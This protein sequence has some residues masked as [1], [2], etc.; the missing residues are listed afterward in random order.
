[1]KKVLTILM[2]SGLSLSADCFGIG[3]ASLS[4][5]NSARAIAKHS[6]LAKDVGLAAVGGAIV[7]GYQGC[8]S[9]CIS[10][11][12]LGLVQNVQKSSVVGSFFRDMSVLSAAEATKVTADGLLTSVFGKVTSIANAVSSVLNC[13]VTCTKIIGYLYSAYIVFNMLSRWMN[14][15]NSQRSSVQ[16]NDLDHVSIWRD[17]QPSL[18]SF[19]PAVASESSSLATRA[20]KSVVPSRSTSSNFSETIIKKVDADKFRTKISS[21]LENFKLESAYGSKVLKD[22]EEWRSEIL[23]ALEKVKGNVHYNELESLKSNLSGYCDS[24][25]S[26]LNSRVV[27]LERNGGDKSLIDALEKDIGT[28]VELDSE[29]W[30]RFYL[31]KKNPEASFGSSG[32]NEGNSNVHSFGVSKKK[33]KSRDID[34][35]KGKFADLL[36]VQIKSSLGE[37]AWGRLSEDR[38]RLLQDLN[39][40]DKNFDFGLLDSLQSSSLG[41]FDE[42]ASGLSTGIFKET[43][44]RQLVFSNDLNTV[45]DQQDKMRKIFID[46]KYRSDEEKPVIKMNGKVVNLY[47]EKLKEAGQDLQK[48]CEE[49]TK[50]LSAASASLAK[51]TP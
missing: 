40:L 16:E 49:Q 21:A 34:N 23:N 39:K 44:Q 26:S 13:A 3:G 28:I 15:V 24:M 10:P 30:D 50:A 27:K 45:R 51:D 8:R 36:N 17:G 38:K 25:W 11:D 7:G 48:M 32:T 43:G 29:V 33:V 42:I 1:M 37:S 9:S 12:L 18:T 19:D 2:V 5:T 47:I 14:I 46:L 31:L 20:I 6:I 22:H 41:Y 4:V 35:F